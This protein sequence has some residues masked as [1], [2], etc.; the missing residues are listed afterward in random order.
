MP[1]Q[2][3]VSD[4]LLQKFI[5]YENPHLGEMV[6]VHYLEVST[7]RLDITPTKA[8]MEPTEP[9]NIDRLRESTTIRF[10][11]LLSSVAS[12]LMNFK[13]KELLICDR[14]TGFVPDL[15]KALFNSFCLDQRNTFYN[16]WLDEIAN[17]YYV[18]LNVQSESKI[19]YPWAT[20]LIRS[21]GNIYLLPPTTRRS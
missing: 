2:F 5:D 21:D 12:G 16:E 18:W 17:E 6:K 7:D 8:P 20:L 10:K 1:N 15:K 11:R 4:A 3:T 14:I 19:E 13:R 9:M